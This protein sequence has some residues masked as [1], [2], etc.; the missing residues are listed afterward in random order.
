MV[1]I[2]VQKLKCGPDYII[3]VI[4][5]VPGLNHGII[6][7]D[8]NSTVLGNYEETTEISNTFLLTMN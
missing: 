7:K 1:Y 6:K 2:S 8:P 5:V 4:N 3:N